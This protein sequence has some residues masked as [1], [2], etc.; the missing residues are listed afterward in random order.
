MKRALAFSILALLAALVVSVAGWML[1]VGRQAS[2]ANDQA[3]PAREASAIAADLPALRQKAE[4]GDA[5]SQNAMGDVYAKGEA[6]GQSYRQ[7]CDWYRKAAEQG[8]ADA[9]FN[10]A[11]LYEVGQG[12][13]KDEAQAAEWFRKAAAQGHSGA[14]YGLG[15]MYASGRGVKQDSAEAA[16][17]FLQSAQGGDSLAQFNVAQRFELGRGT[18]TNLVEACKWYLL[19]S[20]Q[21]VADASDALK[22]LKGRVPADQ[23]AQAERLARDFKP[24]R[25]PAQP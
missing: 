18:A 16:R 19:A 22:A 10:L 4:A 17:W 20:R 25:T 3:P 23:F 9:Q 1:L 7:A 24:V 5:S 11:S 6:V 13:A 12:T 15:S 8:H 14:Q 21:G 2:L